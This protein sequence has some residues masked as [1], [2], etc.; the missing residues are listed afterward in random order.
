MGAK[1][2]DVALAQLVSDLMEEDETLGERMMAEMVQKP[3]NDL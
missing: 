1:G 2:S 3:L